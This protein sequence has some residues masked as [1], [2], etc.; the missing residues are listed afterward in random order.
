[1]SIIAETIAKHMHNQKCVNLVREII[2]KAGTE[3]DNDVPLLMMNLIKDEFGFDQSCGIVEFS[4]IEVTRLTEPVG[5]E[6]RIELKLN[7]GS[8]FYMWVEN[9]HIELSLPSI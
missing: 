5:K 3:N 7:T 2:E 6:T 8:K 9:D 1:M 4:P